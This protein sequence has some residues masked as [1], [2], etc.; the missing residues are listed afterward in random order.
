M[1]H[2]QQHTQNFVIFDDQRIRLLIEAAPVVQIV[3]PKQLTHLDRGTLATRTANEHRRSRCCPPCPR[4]SNYSHAVL[5]RDRRNLAAANIGTNRKSY[6][7]PRY[8]WEVCMMICGAVYGNAPRAGGCFYHK[9][10]DG[11]KGAL[12]W[13]LRGP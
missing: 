7:L 6:S 4:I 3:Y 13:V 10:K 9:T 8:T 5:S 11:K 12:R 1:Y 2:H